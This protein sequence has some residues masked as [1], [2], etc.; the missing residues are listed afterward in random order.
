MSTDET[1]SEDYLD[2][3]VAIIDIVR[4]VEGS[5]SVPK[6]GRGSGGKMLL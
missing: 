1:D 5:T 2:D 3:D 6:G 4:R